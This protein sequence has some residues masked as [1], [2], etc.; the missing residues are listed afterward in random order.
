MV[1]PR[2]LIKRFKLIQ[3]RGDVKKLQKLLRYSN[4]SSVSRVLAGECSTTIPK[5]EKIKRFIED[6][7]K[8]VAAIT[9]SDGN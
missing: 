4:Q 7:E 3:E 9:E 5:V 1:L 2:E 6:R 8:I